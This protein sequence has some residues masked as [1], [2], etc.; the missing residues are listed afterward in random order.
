[1]TQPDFRK[2]V[3]AALAAKGWSAAKL[4]RRLDVSPDTIYRWLRGPT[5][6]LGSNKLERAC[7]LLGIEFR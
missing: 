5:K 1:M 4:A 7:E 3:A 2:L 6:E